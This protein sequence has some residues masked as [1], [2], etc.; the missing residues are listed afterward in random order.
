MQVEQLEIPIIGD[1]G[2]MKLYVYPSSNN[3]VLFEEEDAVDY[4]ESR[5]QLQEGCTY[6]YELIASN[7]RMYQFKSE[8]D[9]V[10]YSNS[11]RHPNAGTIKT[12]IY[13]GALS[14]SIIDIE[15]KYVFTNK[16][17]R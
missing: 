16:S 17:W 6:E 12:G 13:V 15:L 11:P 4:G 14:L 7:G 9:I 8:D 10:R 2:E 5:W 3:S 1:F